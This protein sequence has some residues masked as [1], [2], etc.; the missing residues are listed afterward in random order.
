MG[1]GPRFPF[2][3]WVWSPAGGW[4]CENP[5]NAQRNLRIVLGLNFAI[6]G[7]VFFISAANERR[8][9]SHPTIPV[10]SQRW[11]AW[12]KVDDPDYKRKLAAYHKNKKPLWERI[13]PDAMIQDEHGH[14]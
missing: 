7:A 4:W 9:L 14:H 8:L 2:P 5:P 3:K 13:L 12:T 11:S 6:A 10:P 1:G